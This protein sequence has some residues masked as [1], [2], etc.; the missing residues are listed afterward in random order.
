MVNTIR[1]YGTYPIKLD[2]DVCGAVEAFG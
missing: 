2:F 1:A